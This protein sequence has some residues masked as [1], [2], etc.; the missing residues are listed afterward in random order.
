MAPTGFGLGQNMILIGN[1]GDGTINIFDQN[2]NYKGQLQS[3]GNTL[4][5]DGLWSLTPAP[6]MATRLDQNIVY[7]ST[8]PNS[9]A[10]GLRGSLKLA[11]GSIS[12]CGY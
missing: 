5:I 8:G 9:G 7:F 1:F 3:N 11:P 4:S 10:P 2:G 6:S 12:T